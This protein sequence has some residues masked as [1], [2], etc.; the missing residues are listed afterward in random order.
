MTKAAA[1]VLSGESCQFPSN[2]HLSMTVHSRNLV[3]LWA[4]WLVS[5]HA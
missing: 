4:S 2:V 1:R 5:A 3:D